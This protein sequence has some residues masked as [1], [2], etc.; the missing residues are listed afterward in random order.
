MP[1]DIHLDKLIKRIAELRAGLQTNDPRH[2]A[3][4]TGACPI[5][6]G[7]QVGEFHLALWEQE[8][9]LDYPTFVAHEAQNGAGL[10]DLLQTMLLYYF[11]TS[12]GAPPAGKWISFAELPNGRFYNQAFQGYSGKELARAF[13]E[14]LTAFIEAATQLGGERLHFGDAAFAFQALPRVPLLVVYWLGDEDFPSTGQVLF[15]ESA[16][17]YLPTDACAVLGSMLTQRLIKA[18]RKK[19]AG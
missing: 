16:S 2:L 7:E 3:A 4:R 9:V 10:P 1:H 13:G 6:K 5:E 11:T 17:H 12:D 18:F 15:D 14:N 8:V 19:T